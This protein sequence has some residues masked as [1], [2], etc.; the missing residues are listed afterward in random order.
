MNYKMITVSYD[1]ELR[2]QALLIEEDVAVIFDPTGSIVIDHVKRSATIPGMYEVNTGQHP[3]PIA[4][5]KL[6]GR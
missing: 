2:C 5:F 6:E 4:S 1:A 3:E